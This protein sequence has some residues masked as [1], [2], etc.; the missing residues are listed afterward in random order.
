MRIF[1]QFYIG[2]TINK[3]IDTGKNSTDCESTMHSVESCDEESEVTFFSPASLR[4]NW[5]MTLCKFKELWL[6][7]LHMLSYLIAIIILQKMVMKDFE[8]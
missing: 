5:H 6:G 2:N 3:H 8:E 1:F 4:C 7:I